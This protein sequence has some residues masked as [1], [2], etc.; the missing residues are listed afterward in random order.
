M[1]TIQQ[2]SVVKCGAT[3]IVNRGAHA[4]LLIF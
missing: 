2:K 1:K 4:D 3:V